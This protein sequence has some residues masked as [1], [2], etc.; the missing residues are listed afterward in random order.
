MI[1]GWNVAYFVDGRFA[2]EVDRVVGREGVFVVLRET[3]GSVLY[4]ARED[5]EVAQESDLFFLPDRNRNSLQEHIKDEIFVILMT[6]SCL[7]MK[8]LTRNPTPPSSFF[9]V[10]SFTQF[11]SSMSCTILA[12]ES[13]RTPH[14]K[15]DVI[16]RK[17]T[18][19]RAF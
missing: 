2:V 17:N 4:S 1:S 11:C 16:S 3:D 8:T 10:N 15:C 13:T 7:P 18:N 12:G 14:V 19:V 5:E 9:V 6:S